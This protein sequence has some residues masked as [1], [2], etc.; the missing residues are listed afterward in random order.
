M[1]K[2]LWIQ[3]ALEKGISSFEIYQ[4]IQKGKEISWFDHQMDT[5]V[6]SHVIG[7]SIRGIVDGNMANMAMEQVDDDKIDEVLDQ[8][9]EQAKTVTSEDEA[10]IR[11]PQEIEDIQSSHHWVR[12]SGQQVQELMKRLEEE[13]L[14]YDTRVIQVA[15]L[16]WSESEGTREITNSYGMQI[17]DED[18]VQYLVASVVVQENDVIKDAYLIEVIE[19]LDQ[20]ETGPFV[21]KLCEK[22]LFKLQG[23]S[24]KSNTYPVIFEREAMRQLFSSFIGIFNGDL[25]YKG[26]SP[27]SKKLNERIFSDLITIVDDPRNTDAL[28]TAS[29][30]DEGCP[31][32]KTI[33]VEN[34][35]FQQ[36]LLDTKSARRIGQESTGNGF[37]SGYAS[38]VSIQPMNCQIVPGEKSLEEMCQDMKEGLVI[39]NLQGLHA[40]LDFVTT[41]F[42][43]P[44][45]GYWIKEGHKDHAVSLITVAGNYLELMK[46]VVCVGN[47]LDWEYH[48]VVT[49]SIRFEGCAISGQENE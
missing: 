37:K 8:L 7:T 35:I 22:A 40:G 15:S 3:K 26:I 44:C 33:I 34:G 43:L 5:Y 9:M 19:D 25:I 11:Q 27:I 20:F 36:M 32:Q 47:D 29:F 31:T 14:A 1:N 13:L 6:T 42:S 28:S 4:S 23:T 16:G 46:H 21:E 38:A 18:Q 12:P 49:P 2:E 17:Q 30:D 41:N 10:Y 24:L 45:S 48:Q 39:T